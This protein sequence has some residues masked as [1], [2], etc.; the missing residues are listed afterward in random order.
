MYTLACVKYTLSLY[1][2]YKRV[3]IRM[4]IRV[5]SDFISQIILLHTILYRYDVH[6]TILLK[7]M[8]FGS[9]LVMR[10]RFKKNNN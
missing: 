10:W 6:D 8:Y 2:L 4:C 7:H 9:I 1:T 3:Y 5:K